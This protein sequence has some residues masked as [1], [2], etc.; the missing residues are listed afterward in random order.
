MSK[1]TNKRRVNITLDPYVHDYIKKECKKN[2]INFSQW[3]TEKVY[4]YKSEKDER[5]AKGLSKW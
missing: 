4:E 2:G 1:I 5:I 3:V